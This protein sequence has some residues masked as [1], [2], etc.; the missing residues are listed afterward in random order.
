VIVKEVEDYASERAN[1]IDVE[2]ERCI[3]E[4]Q[5]TRRSINDHL[6]KIEKQFLAALSS[7]HT[8]IKSKLDTLTSRVKNKKKH[9]WSWSS[10]RLLVSKTNVGRF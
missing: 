4:I 6:D 2:K 9:L 10:Q 1:S 5:H 8:K 7:E 3:D